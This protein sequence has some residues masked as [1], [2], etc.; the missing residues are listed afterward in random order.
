M[1]AI[2]LGLAIRW[3]A[4]ITDEAQALRSWWTRMFFSWETSVHLKSFRI[5]RLA[6][7]YCSP[8]SE[9]GARVLECDITMFWKGCHVGQFVV[10]M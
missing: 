8:L 7:L 2:I 5:S 6:A 9:R 1:V 4:R 10:K 3:V